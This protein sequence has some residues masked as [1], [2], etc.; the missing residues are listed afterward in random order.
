MADAPEIHDLA[1]RYL[2][3]WQQQFTQMANDPEI[4][5]AVAKLST[6][7]FPAG[8]AGLS[9]AP[10]YEAGTN[11]TAAAR[12]SSERGGG[13][14]DKLSDRL[15]ALEKRLAALEKKPRTG[16]RSGAGKPRKGGS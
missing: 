15:A 7:V 9:Q 5:A 13:D 14:L 2:D 16:G 10:A 4:A 6:T 1:R 11:G 3:L 12:G 8:V